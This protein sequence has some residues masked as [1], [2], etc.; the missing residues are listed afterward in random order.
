MSVSI[1]PSQ[2]PVQAFIESASKAPVWV[3]PILGLLLPLITHGLLPLLGVRV[4]LEGVTP[5]LLMLSGGALVL[6]LLYLFYFQFVVKHPIVLVIYSTCFL[7]FSMYLCEVVEKTGHHIPFR[8][9]LVPILVIPALYFFL[10]YGFRMIK[11]YPFFKWVLLFLCLYGFYYLFHN[12][13]FADPTVAHKGVLVSIAQGA[14]TDYIYGFSVFVITGSMF[15][16]KG[17]TPEGLEQR[18]KL[19]ELINRFLIIEGTI[20]ALCAIFGYPF[21]VFTMIVEEFK[22]S[23]GFLTHPNEYGK[24]TGMMLI[25]FIGLYYY[26]IKR[27]GEN[28]ALANLFKVL[29]LIAISTNLIA[30]LLTLS[31]NAFVGFGAAGLVYFI[32]AMFD[33]KLR[34]HMVVPLCVMAGMVVL[35]LLSYQVASGKD[36]VT[37][38]TERFNDT[39]SLQWR[40]RVW[41]YLFAQMRPSSLLTGFGLTTGNMEMYRFQ[42]EANVVSE[43]QTV[44]VHNAPL[45]FVFEMGVWGLLIYGGMVSASFNAIKSFFSSKLNP[46]YLT[47]VALSLFIFLGSLV[48]ECITE[49]GLNI[50]FWFMLTMIFSFTQAQKKLNDLN[51]RNNQPL[52]A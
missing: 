14:F 50:L 41:N 2:T 4:F 44:Y 40:N 36:L 28:V 3:W 9:L 27:P 38:L 6:G 7:R 47:P 49:I 21:G 29:L 20:E 48:D 23:S 32:A 33:D 12:Y 11:T 17:E 8:T 35:A 37:L 34:K 15:L 18:V 10:V 22:R 42:F 19:F 52:V 51:L 24:A 5:E 25:Y 16:Q 13:D 46:L 31:K 45:Q 26:Y 1:Q 30:F 39:R 43:K